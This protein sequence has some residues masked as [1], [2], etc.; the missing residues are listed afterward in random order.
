MSLQGQGRT[1]GQGRDLSPAREG[2][3]RNPWN[4]LRAYLYKNLITETKFPII[5]AA[6]QQTFL[7][8]IPGSRP[9]L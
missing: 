2:C 9:K 8:D 6:T 4:F 3:A 5:V 1:R 7:K